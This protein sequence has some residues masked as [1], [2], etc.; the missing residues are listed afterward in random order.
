MTSAQ[1]NL[2]KPGLLKTRMDARASRLSR[3]AEQEHPVEQVGTEL[4]AMM[5]FLDPITVRPDEQT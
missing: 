2:L 3:V 1:V 4:R 5:P